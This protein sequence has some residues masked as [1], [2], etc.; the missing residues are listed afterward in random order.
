MA[1]VVKGLIGVCL[2]SGDS[3]GGSVV[4]SGKFLEKEPRFWAGVA[5][6]GFGRNFL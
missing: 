5:G 2:D 6:F 4:G 1:R 3:L